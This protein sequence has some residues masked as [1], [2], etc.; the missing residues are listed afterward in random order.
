MPRSATEKIGGVG[1][2]SDADPGSVWWVGF[3]VGDRAWAR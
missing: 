3:G 1:A 2:V